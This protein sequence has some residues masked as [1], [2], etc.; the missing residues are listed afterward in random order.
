[1]VQAPNWSGWKERKTRM[2]RG[3]WSGGESRREG[4]LSLYASAENRNT[5]ERPRR[6]GAAGGPL[7]G[8]VCP[9][10]KDQSMGLPVW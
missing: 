10:P 7:C 2:M 1:M 8:S 5:A 4:T 9:A 6:L 3:N